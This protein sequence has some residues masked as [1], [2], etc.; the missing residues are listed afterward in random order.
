MA[1]GEAEE[2]TGDAI[3]GQ[4]RWLVSGQ[5]GA[6]AQCLPKGTIAA[7]ER[8]LKRLRTDR[9]DLYLLHWRGGMPLAETLDAF[10]Q[11]Q[12]RRQDPALGR[13]QFRHR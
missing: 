2:I 10:Q 3:A 8:S 4:A 11:L 12:Q 7:C 6:A 9:I 1:N 5:Q 13:Q